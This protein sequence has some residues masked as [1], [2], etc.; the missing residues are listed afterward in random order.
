MTKRLR[1]ENNRG[2]KEVVCVRGM[3]FSEEWTGVNFP[4]LGDNTNLRDVEYAKTIIANNNDGVVMVHKIG[5][6]RLPEDDAILAG[7]D[8]DDCGIAYGFL[9]EDDE[10]G[11]SSHLSPTAK[12]YIEEPTS[13]KIQVNERQTSTVKKV[14]Y[15]DMFQSFQ[16][17]Y[18][19]A[20][21]DPVEERYLLRKLNE[22]KMEL[23]SRAKEKEQ[24]FDLQITNERNSLTE[25]SCRLM[26]ESTGVTKKISNKWPRAF[27]ER[28]K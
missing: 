16:A 4:I 22:L 13:K 5:G 8:I 1:E 7:E 15:E 24:K 23:A 25:V 21:G 27:Y 12:R 28:K 9:G 2:Y 19:K 6:V 14:S 26:F 18:N 11:F 20:E 17:A 3:T 10:V